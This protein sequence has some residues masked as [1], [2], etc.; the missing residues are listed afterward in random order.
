MHAVLCA[1]KRDRDGT[2][3]QGILENLSNPS[4]DAEPSALFGVFFS[5]ASLSLGSWFAVITF[6]VK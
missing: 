4:R 2:C 3:R 6:W 1:R 5:C